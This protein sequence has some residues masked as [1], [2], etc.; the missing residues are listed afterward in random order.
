MLDD[1]KV[2]DFGR[3]GAALVPGVSGA[4]ERAE[5]LQALGR[6]PLGH[7]GSRNL[8]SQ[9]WCIDLA[10]HLRR[11][12]TL[13]GHLPRH[14]VAF[15]CTYFEKSAALNWL[16]PIHQDLSIPVAARIDVPG[17]QGWSQKEGH[18]FVQP[19]ADLLEQLVAVRL[20]LDD[21]GPEDGPLR[22]VP[23]SHLGGRVSDDEA[24]ALRNR[25]GEVTCTAR[26]GDA[27]LLRPLVL[28]ASSK[29]TGRS[30]RRVLHFVF[31]PAALPHGLAWA[32]S[33]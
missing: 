29:G 11:H 5:I 23:G 19:P 24:S 21:C 27:L 7:A 2:L 28:H 3:D 26:P 13:G 25:I 9:P 6:I 4:A 17:W 1:D 18:W 33:A 10:G 8:L 31:G 15:Q 16:V 30:A 32:Q 20:H 14:H 12:P 22:V